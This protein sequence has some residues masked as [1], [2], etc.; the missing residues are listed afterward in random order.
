MKILDR[1]TQ[2][3]KFEDLKANP[4]L[5][6]KN[7]KVHRLSNERKAAWGCGSNTTRQT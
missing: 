5:G 6:R 3:S 7:G 2:Q 1:F 4:E